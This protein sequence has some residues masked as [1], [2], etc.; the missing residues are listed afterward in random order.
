MPPPSSGHAGGFD[1]GGSSSSRSK[2]S[3]WQCHTPIS[4]PKLL[5]IALRSCDVRLVGRRTFGTHRPQPWLQHLIH[6][7]RPGEHGRVDQVAR[8]VVLIL[9]WPKRRPIISSDAPPETSRD[10]KA[11]RRYGR[12]RGCGRR[13]CGR[14]SLSRLLHLRSEP[15]QVADRLDGHITGEEKRAALRHG[16]PPQPDQVELLVLKFECRGELAKRLCQG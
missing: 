8:W 14:R 12:R 10:A 3:S 16:M 1:G 9:V 7:L 15:L 6:R 4:T 2:F 11:W 13:G 5:M